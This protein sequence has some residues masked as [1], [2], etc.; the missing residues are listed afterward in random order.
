MVRSACA[1]PEGGARPRAGL[2]RSAQYDRPGLRTVPIRNSLQSGHA[3]TRRG[4]SRPGRQRNGRRTRRSP[5][6]VSGCRLPLASPTQVRTLD[7]PP[8]AQTALDQQQRDPARY[9]HW[10]FRCCSS[11]G[12]PQSS[13]EL[14]DLGSELKDAHPAWAERALGFVVSRGRCGPGRGV[15]AGAGQP[16]CPR[17]VDIARGGS[18]GR[19][20]PDHDSCN[21][22]TMVG[23]MIMS[24]ASRVC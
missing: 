21:L 5:R 11:P 3:Q 10:P 20:E 17:L 22:L 4:R 23:T 24:A 1:P 14:K 8:P 16:G 15:L 19:V 12:F 7:L 2:R 9:H 13:A 6:A 18:G